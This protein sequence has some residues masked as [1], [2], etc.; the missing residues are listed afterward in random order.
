MSNSNENKYGLWLLLCL[1]YNS[2]VFSFKMAY[3]MTDRCQT[4]GRSAVVELQVARL[5]NTSLTLTGRGMM[6]ICSS[7]GPPV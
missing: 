5:T 7:G 1:C 4:G 6:G 3:S 2:F